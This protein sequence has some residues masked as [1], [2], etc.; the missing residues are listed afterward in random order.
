MNGYRQPPGKE[1]LETHGRG[2]H[3]AVDLDKFMK[4][5][6]VEMSAFLKCA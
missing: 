4:T 5:D 2:V 6:S 1:Q 3:R